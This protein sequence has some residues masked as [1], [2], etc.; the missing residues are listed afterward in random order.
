MALADIR[1][2]VQANWPS[3]YHSAVLDDDKT[4]EYINAIQR[5]VCRAHNFTWME[6]EVTQDTTDEQ[7]RYA[8]PTAGDSSWTEVG[9]GTV[10]KYKDE[11][12]CELIDYNSYRKELKKL[13]KKS[14]E[15]KKLFK[16]TA[17]KG[18]PTHYCIRAG[19]IELWKLPDH[20]SNNDTAFTINFEFYGYLA[21]LSDSNTSNE[22]T[23]QYPLILEYGATAK[24]YRYGLDIE[25][26]EYYEGL[27]G[28]IFAEMVAEDNSRKFSSIEEGMRPARGQSVGGERAEVLDLKAHY[29]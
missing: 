11:I 12:S 5:E 2:D 27:A 19:Y 15:E 4:D 17:A 22:I 16:D 9:S 28:K 20:D 6:Q 1:S 24:G 10:F 29:E 18:T 23:S 21:D 8:L 13:F 25:M 14:I 3:G 26:A 7:R